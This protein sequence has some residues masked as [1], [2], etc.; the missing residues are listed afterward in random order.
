MQSPTESK[1]TQ[2]PVEEPEEDFLA[3][4]DQQDIDWENMTCVSCD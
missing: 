4:I 2:E 3:N 1:P